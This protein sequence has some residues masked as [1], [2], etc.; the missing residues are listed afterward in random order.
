M[1]EKIKYKLKPVVGKRQC[2]RRIALTVRKTL[3]I[4]DK[5]PNITHKN[6]SLNSIFENSNNDDALDNNVSNISH[7]NISLNSENEDNDINNILKNN[8]SSNYDASLSLTLS[9]NTLVSSD[10]NSTVSQPF[11]L[12]VKTVGF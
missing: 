11:K 2:Y 12:N 4:C 3:Q 1:P 10:L 6:I 7:G 9:D 5:K 8:V